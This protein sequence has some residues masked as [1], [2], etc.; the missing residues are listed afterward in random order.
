MPV[1]FNS[2]A[3]NLFLLGSTGSQVVGN[4]FKTIDKSAGTDG[5]YA[6]DEIAY[7]VIDQK[8]FLA[9][10][11]ASIVIRELLDGLRKE[12]RQEQRILI[13]HYNRRSLQKTQLYV[14]WSWM[15]III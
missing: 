8:Y 10:T 1:G 7:N 15:L 6:P 4:F 13:S 11:A 9:G 12:M 3:R 14:P 2:P 5:V